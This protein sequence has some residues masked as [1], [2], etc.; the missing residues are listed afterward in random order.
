VR[1]NA[2]QNRAPA[3]ALL[4]RAS[5]AK[6]FTGRIVS[7]VSYDRAMTVIADAV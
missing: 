7:R 5:Q 6:D 3:V 1:R 4:T 2:R